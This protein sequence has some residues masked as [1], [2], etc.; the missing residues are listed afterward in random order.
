MS[1]VAA[2]LQKGAKCR[3]L[4]VFNIQHRIQLCFL[5]HVLHD[6]CR[7]KQLQFG[8]VIPHA[9]ESTDKTAYT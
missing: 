7:A 6:F 1:Y 8:F 9:S 2:N 5:H 4:V 3:G